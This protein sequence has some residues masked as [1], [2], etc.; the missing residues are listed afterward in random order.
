MCK[1][2]C[3]QWSTIVVLCLLLLV[4]GP[5]LT[6]CGG[7]DGTP[8]PE[9][10]NEEEAVPKKE[11]VT[12]EGGEE[13]LTTEAEAEE[14]EQMPETEVKI[15]YLGHSAFLLEA[16]EVRILMDPYSSGTGGYGTLSLEAD[17]VT[18]SHEHSDHNYIQAAQGSPQVLRGLTE[19]GLQWQDVDFSINGISFGSVNT[20]HDDAGG[21]A[22]GRNA[23]FIV[24]ADDLRLVHLG[25]L[26]HLLNEDQVQGLSPVDILFIPTG[27]HYTIGPKEAEQVIEQLNPR[28]VVP[29]HYRTQA[30][31][32]WPLQD[33]D[34]FLEG[35]DNIN[36]RGEKTVTVS[37]STLPESREIWPLSF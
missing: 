31:A 6:G 11:D 26:G 2:R 28:V 10:G 9:E 5:F 7:D 19:D 20:Y 4:A 33:L 25:D 14:V 37:K 17:V 18:A 12:G 21:S 35:K 8:V 29:M 13:E 30:I 3:L 15:T 16:G 27:G 22:R 24:Q 32:D 1:R 36:H 23:A 34:A